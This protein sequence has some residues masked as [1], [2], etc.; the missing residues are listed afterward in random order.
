MLRP[1]RAVIAVGLRKDGA[2]RRGRAPDIF[3]PGSRSFLHTCPVARQK[4]YV[5]GS[6]RLAVVWAAAAFALLAV[7]TAAA[8]AGDVAKA[9]RDLASAKD[10][11]QSERWDNLESS[12]K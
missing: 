4:D 12:M 1:A 10:A 8:E 5:M 6:I 7:F 11:A 9:K 2:L 3:L